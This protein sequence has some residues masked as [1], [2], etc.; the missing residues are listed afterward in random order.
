MTFMNAMNGDIH[1]EQQNY[2]EFDEPKRSIESSKMK[3]K[4]TRI[5]LDSIFDVWLPAASDYDVLWW[6][7]NLLLF[8]VIER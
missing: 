7:R 8:Q 4:K 6:V 3:K 2:F 5:E 1:H